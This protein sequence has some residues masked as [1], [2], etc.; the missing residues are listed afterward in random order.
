MLYNT[1]LC[2]GTIVFL[3]DEGNSICWIEHIHVAKNCMNDTS[4]V[5]IRTV[6]IA[7][8]APFLISGESQEHEKYVYWNNQDFCNVVYMWDSY[9]Y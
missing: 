4:V 9:N 6:I 1:L 2:E 7:L 8:N 3:M 5:V